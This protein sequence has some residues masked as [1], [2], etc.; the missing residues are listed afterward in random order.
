MRPQRSRR[1]CL[2]VP[3]SSERFLAKARTLP[4]DHVF[5]DLEDAVA[6]LAKVEAR[7]TV[8]RA[9]AE[10]GWEGKVRT[11]RVN[12]PG[13]PWAVRD[14]VDVVEGAGDR[15]DCVVLPKVQDAGQ[16]R[17]LDET[18]TS[19][20]LAAGLE[21][22]R[23]G[24]EAQLEDARGLVHA[25]A[26]AE[27]SARV[28]A[29]V[30]GPGD[31]IASTR[32][33]TLTIGEQPEGYD[34][35][36]AYHAVLVQILLAARARGIQ[37]VD[38]PYPA[39]RDVDGFRRVKGRSAALGYDGTWVLHPAQVEAANE[40]FSP[41]VQDYERA[42]RILAAYER[43]LSS[44]GGARGALLVD[45]EMVDEA[46]RKMAEVVVAQGRAAGLDAPV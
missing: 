34:V 26:I 40:L 14:V 7:A 11:V 37:A 33:R 44:E 8:T 23:I 12:P 38:G 18:L 19:L 1:S 6:P 36:D 35:G 4:V 39:V 20:E 32:M 17:W 28:E 31:F 30:F 25:V 42:E 43:S 9:L 46:T 41:R 45:G 27:A 22:G 15:L 29:L 13:T 16:V 24:I 21:P 3:G 10:G 2:A 5:L